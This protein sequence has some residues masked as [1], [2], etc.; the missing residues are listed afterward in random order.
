MSGQLEMCAF[1]SVL[2]ILRSF[3]SLLFASLSAPPSAP[4]TLVFPLFNY[5]P[6]ERTREL[7]ELGVN[8]RVARGGF[9]RRTRERYIR[10]V[11]ETGGHK[12]EIHT[13]LGGKWSKL[14]A[15]QGRDDHRDKLEHKF[16]DCITVMKTNI[17]AAAGVGTRVS[18]I[19]RMRLASPS[20]LTENGGMWKLFK[21][22][23]DMNISINSDV[24]KH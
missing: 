1:F 22:K 6:H 5:R 19:R 17:R 23:P 10:V 7:Q 3:S 16:S 21:Q 20:S 11:L 8:R 18:R 9:A 4:Q 14:S 15:C 2:T 12:K 13:F 24:L